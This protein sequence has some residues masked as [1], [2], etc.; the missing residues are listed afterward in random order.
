[1]I[2]TVK[3]KDGK[4]IAYGAWDIC[5]KNGAYNPSWPI[6]DM[7]YSYIEK[8]WIHRDYRHML[9]KFFIAMLVSGWDRFPHVKYVYFDRTKNGKQ[10]HGTRIY[11]VTRLIDKFM[12]KGE[13]I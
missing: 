10:I 13:G 4:V 12:E 11:K 6:E 5:D 8:I 3:D 9:K 1:M 7:D 2:E